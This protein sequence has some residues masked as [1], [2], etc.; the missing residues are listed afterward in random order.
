MGDAGAI[1]GV[2]GLRGAVTPVQPPETP[3]KGRCRSAAILVQGIVHPDRPLRAGRLRCE[4]RTCQHPSHDGE[5]LE[6]RKADKQHDQ[7]AFNRQAA[8]PSLF[9]AMKVV[10]RQG[11]GKV[12]D[13]MTSLQ[14]HAEWVRCVSLRKR[15]Y[16]L[17]VS[18]L[19]CEAVEKVSS[20]SRGHGQAHVGVK[21]TPFT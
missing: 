16:P 11:P 1:A 18:S 3:A 12:L 19:C 15:M 2:S 7:R 8:L 4:R 5:E 9:Q 13:D 10:T 20:A 21:T 14:I 6:R 17:T